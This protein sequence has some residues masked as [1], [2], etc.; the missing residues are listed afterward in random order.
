MSTISDGRPAAQNLVSDRK[1]TGAQGT[2]DKLATLES[3]IEKLR[4]QVYSIKFYFFAILVAIPAVLLV[5]TSFYSLR[6]FSTV[7][8]KDCFATGRGLEMA[9]VGKQVNVV[10]YTV[11]T[12]TSGKGY[13]TQMETIAC[14]LVSEPSR[15]KVDCNVK[16][17]MDN[18]YEISYQPT[19]QGGH[20]LHIKVEGEHIKGSPFSIFALKKFGAPM[21]PIGTIT[22]L[23]AP[24][25]M[26]FNQTGH[27]I[28]VE[29]RGH[30]VTIFNKLGDKVYSF[31]SQG[32]G[33]EKFY[34]PCDV[35]VDDDGYI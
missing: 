26:T 5:S 8:P 16:K 10:L 13:N 34:Y 17:V 1:L 19:S 4:K 3:E 24:Q 14:E 27:M 21:I 7:S 11:D 32:S 25:G 2:N 23:S 6:L 28:V 22:G 31:G 9:V 35:A 20:Q 15:T 29:Y 30:K 33:P 12:C 18:Q